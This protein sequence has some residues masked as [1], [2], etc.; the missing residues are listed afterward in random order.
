MSEPFAENKSFHIQN[1]ISFVDAMVQTFLCQGDI[2]TVTYYVNVDGL[3]TCLFCYGG[4]HDIM[5]LQISSIITS[6]KLMN[7]DM[8]SCRRCLFSL[9]QTL[10]QR[11][12]HVSGA[13]VV[14]IVWVSII[15]V[16]LLIITLGGRGSVLHLKCSHRG[17]FNSLSMTCFSIINNLRLGINDLQPGINAL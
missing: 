8:A 10:S 12:D 7:F 14:C 4:Q 6:I 5:L 9:S 3:L 16:I 2:C 15:K 13:T 11:C 17:V 1:P